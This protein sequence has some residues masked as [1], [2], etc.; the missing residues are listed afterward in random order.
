MVTI[1][2]KNPNATSNIKKTIKQKVAEEEME[3]KT[4]EALAEE[5]EIYKVLPV[6]VKTK[7]IMD[8]AEGEVEGDDYLVVQGET[9]A[10]RV[11]VESLLSSDGDVS[12]I[13][14]G[15]T[16]YLPDEDGIVT[17]PDELATVEYVDQKIAEAQ[18]GGGAS[19]EVYLSGFASKEDLEGKVDKEEGKSLVDDAEIERLAGVHNYDDAE[20]RQMIEA[21]KGQ[22]GEVKDHVKS[23]DQVVATKD[24]VKE[25]VD[26]IEHLDIQL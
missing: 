13:V 25:I 18:L 2:P 22:L 1:K 21:T 12:K 7:K 5:E 26:M 6:A 19:G 8:Y 4:V 10:K 20:L 14:I 23:M 11:S 3:V 24:Y 16:E 15:D 17:I 9:E